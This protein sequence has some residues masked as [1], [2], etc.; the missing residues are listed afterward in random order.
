MQSHHKISVH[1]NFWGKAHP[2]SDRKKVRERGRSKTRV[3]GYLRHLCLNQCLISLLKK[4]RV[5]RKTVAECNSNQIHQLIGTNSMAI[6]TSAFY[7]YAASS[8]NIC[9][10]QLLGRGPSEIRPKE[11]A[12]T[13]AVKNQGVWISQT[14][15]PGSMSDNPSQKTQGV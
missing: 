11:S 3:Y 13:R 15:M 9:T 2:R 14:F 1:P 6:N 7:L 8:Q 4:T 12:G 5:Y 10:P